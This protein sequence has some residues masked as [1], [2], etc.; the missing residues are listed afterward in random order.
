[1]KTEGLDIQGLT[2]LADIFSDGHFTLMK[3]T[4]GWKASFSTPTCRED[5][6]GMSVGETA[7]KAIRAAI[8][9]QVKHMS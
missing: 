9:Q 7:Q 6:D 1:M 8:V 4:T 2:V 5:I 3:F